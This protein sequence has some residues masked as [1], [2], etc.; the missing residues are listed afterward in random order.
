[1]SKKFLVILVLLMMSII[2]F[3][4]ISY[5]L[6]KQQ[7]P[8]AQSSQDEH[9][10]DI[11]RA[12]KVNFI[13]SLKSNGTR[14]DSIQLKDSTG[15]LTMLKDLL[16]DGN[17]HT[18]VYRFSE[19]HCSSCVSAALQ[20]FLKWKLS[21]DEKNTLILGNYQNNRIFNRTKQTYAI[22][23]LNVYNSSRLELFAEELGFPYFF[24]L[25]KDGTITNIFVPDK[26]TPELTND[27][28]KMINERY[29]KK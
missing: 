25:T 26:A 13:A 27:Y 19:F 2:I 6:S 10:K 5:Y 8:V 16:R 22:Q 24:L 29:F 23:N 18:L 17:N 12:Y 28:F 14:L 20:A 1:M 9:E 7:Q 3:T 4:G 15:K 11:L 21:I